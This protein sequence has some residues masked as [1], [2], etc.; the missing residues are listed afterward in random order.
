M[1]YVNARQPIVAM[2]ALLLDG[3]QPPVEQSRQMAA[4]SL[5]RDIGNHRELSRGQRSAV[6]ER[7]QHRRAPRIAEES[8]HI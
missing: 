6:H 4:G 5:R 2:P 8:G 3:K 7:N 1:C